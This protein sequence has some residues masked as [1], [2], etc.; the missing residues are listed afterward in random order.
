MA[1]PEARRGG[2]PPIRR[3]RIP[4]KGGPA[5]ACSKQLYPTEPWS[6]ICCKIRFSSSRP[7]PDF[8]NSSRRIAS[9]RDANFSWYTKTQAPRFFVDFVIP[10]LCWPSRRVRSEVKPM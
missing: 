9:T 8:K 7:S 1:R 5:T 10:E 6:S 4:D 2:E 3:R